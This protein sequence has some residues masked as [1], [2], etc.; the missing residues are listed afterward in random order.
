MLETPA[1]LL[2]DNELHVLALRGRLFR[3]GGNNVALASDESEAMD[4]LQNQPVFAIIVDY[5][6]LGMDGQAI[7]KRLRRMYPDMVI[8]M[9]NEGGETKGVNHLIKENIIDKNFDHPIENS[10]LLDFLG[11]SFNQ[12]LLKNA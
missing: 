8:I 7:L 12:F 5:R 2:I 6:I 9:L 10:Q 1:L 4:V 3:H 11:E